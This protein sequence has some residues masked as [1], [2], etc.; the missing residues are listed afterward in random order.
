MTHAK[1][2]EIYSK[3]RRFGKLAFICA[4]PMMIALLGV[5]VWCFID[6]L[7]LNLAI[8]LG[9]ISIPSLGMAIIFGSKE[10]KYHNIAEDYICIKI[11]EVIE[12]NG[13]DPVSFQ[14]IQLCCNEYVIGFHNQTVDYES[15]REN[16]NEE[17]KV[18]NK[19]AHRV[20][21]VNLI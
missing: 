20:I 7:S 1:L 2:N 8:V 16:L 15:L 21:R 18:M 9:I 4:A 17:L 10:T 5:L 14:L 11:G 6:E 12:A 13:V 19:I 3:E